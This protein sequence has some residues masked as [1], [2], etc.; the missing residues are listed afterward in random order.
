MY[1][2]IIYLWNYGN[3]ENRYFM[4]KFLEYHLCVNICLHLED[5]NTKR[6]KK[7]A[8]YEKSFVAVTQSSSVNKVFKSSPVHNCHGEF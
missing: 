5:I 2:S 8:K 4:W 3:S 6:E 7:A 1:G